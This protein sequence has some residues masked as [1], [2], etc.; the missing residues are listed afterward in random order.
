MSRY[1]LILVS[2]DR[3]K[4]NSILA[5]KKWIR[6][7]LVEWVEE[8]NRNRTPERYGKLLTTT[9]S[10]TNNSRQTTL[11]NLFVQHNGQIK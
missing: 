2:Y 10:T 6:E 3:H 9:L 5:E 8:R 7:N 4:D 1:R 11:F